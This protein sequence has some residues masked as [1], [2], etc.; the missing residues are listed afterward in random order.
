M[1]DMSSALL[2][3]QPG[4][5]TEVLCRLAEGEK[6]KSCL[7]LHAGPWVE[8]Q[9]QEEGQKGVMVQAQQATRH[10]IATHSTTRHRGMGETVWAGVGGGG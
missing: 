2:D 7:L 1:K 10:H 8:G 3:E 4:Q 9:E 6:K 5:E